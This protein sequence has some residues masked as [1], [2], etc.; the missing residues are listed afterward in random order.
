VQLHGIGEGGM[1]RGERER[2]GGKE[3]EIN[4]Y[5]DR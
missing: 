3:R 5:R 2:I 1:E 4:R